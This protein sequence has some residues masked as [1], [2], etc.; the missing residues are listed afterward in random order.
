MPVSQAW[1]TLP[2]W[3]DVDL[4][5]SLNRETSYEETAGYCTSHDR[6]EDH[7]LPGRLVGGT[8]RPALPTTASCEKNSE[9]TFAANADDGL[10]N[11]EWLGMSAL[12][13]NGLLVGAVGAAGSVLGR[14]V[15]FLERF[16]AEGPRPRKRYGTPPSRPAS[17]SAPWNAPR[18][19]SPSAPDRSKRMAAPSTTVACATRPCSPATR[20]R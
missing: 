8:A 17:R 13:A 14:A 2:I 6:D 1:P 11:V 18:A 3:L 7:P 4:A 10:P 15:A 16:L 20:P 19:A 5:V 12:A 9:C